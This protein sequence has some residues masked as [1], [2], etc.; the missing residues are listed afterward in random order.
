VALLFA[1]EA[2]WCDRFPTPSSQVVEH[3]HLG[4]CLNAQDQKRAGG[5]RLGTPL[6]LPSSV[7]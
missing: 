7:S 3:A 6:L 5:K 2:G 4:G 1:S